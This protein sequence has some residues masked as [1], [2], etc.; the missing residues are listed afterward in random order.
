MDIPLRAHASSASRACS[1]R[2]YRCAAS[3]RTSDPPVIPLLLAAHYRP[4]EDRPEPCPRG[5][6]EDRTL[7]QTVECASDSP[8]V[9]EVLGVRERLGS[10]ALAGDVDAL[11][12]LLYAQVVVNDPGNR[13]RRRDDLLSL[14]EQQAVVYSSVSSTVE[15]AEE[16]GDLVV[17]MGT[18]ET[19]LEAAPAGAP[20]GAGAR[21]FRRFTDV[22]KKESGTWRLFVRQSTVFKVE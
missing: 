20:W 15:F 6:W 8:A 12:E 22:F 4:P 11:R 2:Q 9:A 1:S 16:L 18:Q 5:T 17:V 21:L 10:A 14:F 7:T 3:R 19:V 13:I